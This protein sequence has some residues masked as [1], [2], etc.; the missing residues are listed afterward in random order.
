MFSLVPLALTR[1]TLHP[2]GRY[3]AQRENP[4]ITKN[5]E[6]WNRF[7]SRQFI[8]NLKKIKRLQD[9]PLPDKAELLLN[10][11]I[12]MKYLKL[13]QYSRIDSSNPDGPLGKLPPIIYEKMYQQIKKVLYPEQAQS[14]EEQKRST[15]SSKPRDQ[16]NGSGF[17]FTPPHYSLRMG[18]LST[19]PQGDAINKKL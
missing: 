1:K 11:E 10:P 6:K 12:R 13:D 19:F 3:E 14:S 5:M 18:F 16:T 17:S 4:T 7:T 15:Q 2:E 9:K 8:D